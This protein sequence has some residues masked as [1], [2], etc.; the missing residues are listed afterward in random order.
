MTEAAHPTRDAL[1]DAGVRV[2]ADKGLVRATVEDITAAAGV[3]KGTFYIHFADR[4][5]FLVAVHGRFAS[6]VGRALRDAAASLPP[7][8]DRLLAGAR[9]YLD[10]CRA[11]PALKALVLESRSEPA[12]HAVEAERTRWFAQLAEE[13]FRAER[14]PQPESAARLF[15]AMCAEAALI[16][17]EGD[18]VDGAARN[19]LA[20]FLGADAERAQT[21]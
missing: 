4:S 7:G 14:W 17:L 16:E 3:A 18:R 5:A 6:T 20:R 9:A 11:L 21:G 1:L 12:T 10:V 15:V 13:D 8:R 19:A 2:V